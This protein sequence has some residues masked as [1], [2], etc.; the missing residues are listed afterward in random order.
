MKSGMLRV[1]ASVQKSANPLAISLLG[2]SFL[3]KAAQVSVE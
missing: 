2:K 1:A 3:G